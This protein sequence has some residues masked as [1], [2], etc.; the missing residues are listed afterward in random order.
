MLHPYET[1][2]EGN[3]KQKCVKKIRLNLQE[4]PFAVSLAFHQSQWY[5]IT[6]KTHV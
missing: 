5:N 6:I 2:T 1:V 3:K 4:M